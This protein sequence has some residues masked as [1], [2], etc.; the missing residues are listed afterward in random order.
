MR[1][2]IAAW[3]ATLLVAVAA[4]GC[5]SSG[6]NQARAADQMQD[7]D[8]AVARYTRVVREHPDNIEARQGLE[9]ARLRAADAH[10]LAG[11]RLVAQGRYEDAL[12]ELQLATELN[13]ANADADRELQQARVALRTQLSADAD[14]RTPLQVLLARTQAL[15]PAS[16]DL[17]GT[18]EVDVRTGSQSTTRDVYQLLGQI[19]HVSVAFDPSVR[20]VPAPLSLQRGLSLRAAFDAVARA[21]RTFFIVTAPSTILVV[22]D[23]PSARREHVEDVVRQFTVQNADLKETMDALRIVADARYVAPVTGTNTILVRD[24]PDRMQVIGRFLAAFDKARPEVVVNVEVL[25]VDRT[26]LTEYGLQLASA[27]S[28]GIDGSADVNRDGLTIQSLRNLGQADVL[29]TNIPTLYYR[30]LKTDSR[31][32]TL[33]NPHLRMTDGTNG[34]ANFGQRVPIPRTRIAPI[35]QG[36]LDIQPQTSFDYESI[37]V[38][39]G[40]TPRTHPNDDVTLGLDIELSSLGAPGFDGLPTFGSRNVKTSIRLRDGETNILAGLIREDERAE[41]QTIPGLGDIPVLGQLFG[42]TRREAQQTDVVI[43]LTP[44]IVRS[45]DLTEDDLRPLRLPRDGAGSVAIE[46][47]PIVFPPPRDPGGVPVPGP[48]PAPGF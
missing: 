9:R 22:A 29:M 15:E 7:H 10:F 12:I 35:T 28:T 23:T 21:T 20:P 34:T 18:L 36:G 5:A 47:A 11:R 17:P 46:S 25:E 19:A 2:A 43:M 48:T 4:W 24:T 31:T 41:R 44:H 39:I 37:G 42:R 6:L 8:L 45:L 40:I 14:S 30:L 1:R 27:G 33:A 32:R 38:N 26:R 13:P 16:N 3:S